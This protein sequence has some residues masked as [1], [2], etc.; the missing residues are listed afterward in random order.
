MMSD[1]CDWHNNYLQLLRTT[2]GCVQE[3]LVRIWL[4]SH[5]LQDPHKE[6]QQVKDIDPGREKPFH[7]VSHS[8]WL[9]LNGAVLL[10]F[11][12]LI[13]QAPRYCLRHT[14]LSSTPL[15]LKTDRP[16]H[17]PFLSFQLTRAPCPCFDGMIILLTIFFQN[18]SEFMIKLNFRYVISLLNLN[19]KRNY[20][21]CVPPT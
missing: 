5:H 10:S 6:L 4:P 17:L 3:R 9:V 15:R 21:R 8:R 7:G 2:W 20:L 19:P 14:L 13:K 12:N 16:I 1:D 11:P 18:H